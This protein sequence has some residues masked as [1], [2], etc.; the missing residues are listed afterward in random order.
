MIREP[1]KKNLMI[2]CVKRSAKIEEKQSRAITTV[3]GHQKVV[4]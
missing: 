4:K 3:N 2:D 1:L